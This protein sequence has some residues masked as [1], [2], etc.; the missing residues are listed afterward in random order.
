MKSI[1]VSL[2]IVATGFFIVA[3]AQASDSGWVSFKR[4]ISISRTARAKSEIPVSMKCRNGSSN[5]ALLKLEIRVVTKP[6]R[7]KRNWIIF[8]ADRQ[9]R[10]GANPSEW[11]NWRKVSGGVVKRSGSGITAYCFL[12]YHKSAGS[13]TMASPPIS[14]KTGGGFVVLN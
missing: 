5:R 1:A 13:F 9:Y 7:D 12:Y 2:G 6:N 8:T 4:L 11:N 3:P 10:P 14:I